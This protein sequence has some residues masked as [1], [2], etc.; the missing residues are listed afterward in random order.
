MRFS[1]LFLAGKG[2]TGLLAC[3]LVERLGGVPNMQKAHGILTGSVSVPGKPEKQDDHA[4]GEDIE[5]GSI[6]GPTTL[7][8]TY[9][10]EPT[11]LSV[12]LRHPLAPEKK[13]KHKK[14]ESKY[15]IPEQE[16]FEQHPATEIFAF[17]TSRSV[18]SLIHLL[19][20]GV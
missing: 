10:E 13:K 8:S 17:H 3:C 20:D 4:E 12:P 15:K 9:S 2:R 14:G 7:T 6:T 19:L 11:V 5:G 16:M 18:T 1:L